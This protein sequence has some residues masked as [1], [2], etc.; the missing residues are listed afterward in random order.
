[1]NSLSEMLQYAQ[2]IQNA[3]P[4]YKIGGDLKAGYLH[5]LQDAPLQKQRD[6][7]NA[8]NIM[9][10][11]NRINATQTLDQFTGN[12]T[13]FSSL[14]GLKNS[15]GKSIFDVTPKI[16]TVPPGLTPSGMT[17]DSSG[18]KIS[19]GS[20]DPTL[21][22]LLIK[23]TI[24]EKNWVSEKL[25]ADAAKSVANAETKTNDAESKKTQ[26]LLKNAQNI[27]QN[28]DNLSKSNN[29]TDIKILEQIEQEKSNVNAMIIDYSVNGNTDAFANLVPMSLQKETSKNMFGM[30]K[31]KI[32][33]KAKTNVT[34]MTDTVATKNTIQPNGKIK[35]KR[36]SDGETGTIDK[37]DFNSSKYVKI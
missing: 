7:E 30:P 27:S 31:E 33:F 36:I 37:K 19:Y 35:V 34:P 15:E 5:S 12:K 2:A 16:S 9:E 22:D 4:G 28:Y 21:Q 18:A 25:K 10:I 1:M 29:I 17:I 26:A 14:A 3:D 20:K 11:Q 13:D 6:L 24:N 23:A 8:K 32:V